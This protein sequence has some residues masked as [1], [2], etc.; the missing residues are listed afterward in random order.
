[1]ANVQHSAL[2]GADLHEPKGA[3]AAAAGR[4]YVA[5]GAASG[6]WTALQDIYTGVLTDVSTAETIYIP[7][8][9]AG[10]VTK[11]VTILEG[12]I[13]TAD[14]TLTPKNAAGSSMGT[15]TVTQSGSAAGDTD[16]LAPASNNTVAANAAITIETDGASSTAQRIWFTF[17]V[18]RTS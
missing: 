18:D 16:T 8:A 3:A 13:T 17:V 11:V 10:T 12:A 4:A 6:A 1:M 9:N 14:A 15:I 2:T 7:I 5:D